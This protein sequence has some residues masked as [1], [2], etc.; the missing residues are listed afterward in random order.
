MVEVTYHNSEIE[1]L[2]KRGASRTYQ[3]LTGKRGF[4]KALFAFRAILSV[5][6]NITDLKSYKWLMLKNG[7]DFSSVTIVAYSVCGI[8]L[9]KEENLGHSIRIHDLIIN[10]DYG[11]ERSL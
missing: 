11:K 3:K 2:M 5:I 1:S 10:Y 9:F 7:V 8:L 6:D 4:M